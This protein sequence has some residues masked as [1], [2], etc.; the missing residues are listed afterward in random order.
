[1]G[2]EYDGRVLDSRGA[3][4]VLAGR[5]RVLFSGHCFSLCLRMLI[6]VPTHRR[7]EPLIHLLPAFPAYFSFSVGSAGQTA[8]CYP[9]VHRAA[10]VTEVAGFVGVAL[11]VTFPRLAA[12][13]LLNASILFG[14]G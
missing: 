13:R 7:C 2:A 11:R 14:A 10:V 9:L 6:V 5:A 12:K 3:P 4:L 8:A 1:M